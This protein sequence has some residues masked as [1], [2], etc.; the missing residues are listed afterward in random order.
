M[1]LSALVLHNV[2]PDMFFRYDPETSQL[3]HAHEFQVVA[4]NIDKA[5]DLIWMLTNV[6]DSNEL[7]SM[8]SD[9]GLYGAQV[10]EYRARGNR[11]LSV[12]DVLVFHEA[13]AEQG[14]LTL[15]R[16][17]FAGA[18]W[19]DTLGFKPALKTSFDGGGSNQ[20]ERS[21]SYEAHVRR[22]A[23]PTSGLRVSGG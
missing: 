21:Q 23:D 16:G 5:A 10:D 8:R 4:D 7:R 9:L 11:S 20:T 3:Y 17:R 15:G 18:L 19:V 14:G 6:G 12:G 1:N 2:S 13:S 22:A